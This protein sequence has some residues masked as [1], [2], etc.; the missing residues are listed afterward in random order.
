[1]TMAIMGVYQMPS[2]K[3]GHLAKLELISSNNFALATVACLVIYYG[4]VFIF[5]LTVKK[6]NGPPKISPVI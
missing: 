2:E 6:V 4:N 1:M 3:L 5:K